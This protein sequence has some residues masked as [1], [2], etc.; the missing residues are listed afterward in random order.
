MNRFLSYIAFV[1]IFFLVFFLVIETGL[2]LLGQR[3][4]STINRFDPDLGWVKKE[5]ES[6]TRNTSEYNVTYKINKLGLRDDRDLLVDKPVNER[7]VIFLGD[8][9]TLGYTVDRKDLFVDILENTLSKEKRKYA[10]QMINA[11]TEGYSSDQELFW[12]WKYGWKM[13]PEIVVMNFYENDIFWNSEDHYQHFPK[14]IFPI[15]GIENNLM[16]SK[17]K[18]PGEQSWFTSHTAVGK[19]I[20]SLQTSLPTFEYKPGNQLFKEMGV[21]LN[22]KE[23]YIIKALDHTKAILKAFKS[24]CEERKIKPV[25]AFIPSKA[26][27]YKEFKDKLGE[28]LKLNDDEWNPNLPMERVK[29]LCREI[30]LDFIDPLPF[31]MDQ[32]EKGIDLYYKIDRHFSPKGNQVFAQVLYN[33]L[34]TSQYLGVP[35]GEPASILTD[36]KEPERKTDTDDKDKG[37]PI[38]LMVVLG[39]WIFLGILYGLSYKDE[40]GLISFMKVGA[41]IWMVV[42]LISLI[43]WLSGLLGSYG[44]LL[45]AL[46]FL[47]IIIFLLWKLGKRA[48]LIWELYIAFTNRGHWYM[49]PLLAVMLAIGSLLIV[50]ASSPFVAPFIYTLF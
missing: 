25:L 37:F 5:G 1:A 46:I 10:F 26:Q 31:F 11:G 14:P 15:E 47:G 38:W 30:G 34:V 49:M 19:F 4:Q 45:F 23:E 7:R 22:A 40:N 48:G 33:H 24:S 17:L 20:S 6:S 13:S 42:G 29:N 3:S 35:D 36:E 27:V 39:L 8:S 18:D 32:A 12:L 50:A 2:R 43:T 16:E 21:L 44:G 41:M 28:R 9:F